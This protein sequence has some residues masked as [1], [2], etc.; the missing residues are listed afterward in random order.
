MAGMEERFAPPA[1]F[2]GAIDQLHDL[3]SQQLGTKDFGPPD[4]LPGL[5]VLLMSMDYDPHFSERGRRIAWGE[6]V[7]ALFGRA[8]AIKFMAQQPGFDAHAIRRPLVITGVPRTGT[9]ALHKLLAVDPQLQG[10]QTWL[11][12]APMPRPPRASW[13]DNPF[14]QQT[15]E[16]LKARY[17]SAPKSRAAHL[18]VADEVDECLFI[19]RQGFVSNLWNCGWSA[20][21]YDAWWQSQ[22]ELP[23]YQHLLRTL[24]LIGSNEP[25]KRWLLKNPGHLANLDL[26]FAIFPDAL[27]IQ[28]HRDPAK[29]VPSLCALLM[30]RHPIM[31]VGRRRERAYMLS[32]RETAK[33]SAAVRAAEAIRASRGD[34]MMDVVHGDFHR[35]PMQTVEDIYAFAGLELTSQVRSAMTE[36]IT[37]KPESTHGEH[38]YDV[39]D[40]GMT[41]AEIRASFGNYMNR[42]DL[43]DQAVARGRIR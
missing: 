4:Y 40:F 8:H 19:L 34:Q 2:A 18:M 17:D 7:S 41:P 37:A 11:V 13:D 1:R 26:V 9:T 12:R 24:Q 43:L 32:A 6:V 22:S 21:S 35:N 42:F 30:H 33:W 31:E 15:V 10:L 28:T 16:Q 27:V 14:F 25:H 3:V 5:K 20:A 23:C 36:R 39:A 29:A 38:Q